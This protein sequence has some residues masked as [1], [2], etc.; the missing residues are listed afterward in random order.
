[1]QKEPHRRPTFAQV[2]QATRQDAAERAWDRAEMAS[3][4][5]H[6]AIAKG[7][8]RVA[9][10]LGEVK[11]GCIVRAMELAKARVRVRTHSVRGMRLWSI[12]LLRRALYLP[13]SM[14]L[15]VSAF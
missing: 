2:L 14:Q 4:L 8:F 12:K 13:L 6:A 9:H 1:M 10:R 3:A 5:R 7:R 15:P 11:H